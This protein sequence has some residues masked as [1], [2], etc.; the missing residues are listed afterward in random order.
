MMKKIER[1]Q[2][3][4]KVQVNENHLQNRATSLHRPHLQQLRLSLDT[5]SSVGSNIDGASG[6]LN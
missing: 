3:Q 5:A 4:E 2:E 1:P 6:S